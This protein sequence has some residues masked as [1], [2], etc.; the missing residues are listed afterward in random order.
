M[1]YPNTLQR[2]MVGTIVETPITG[3]A[4]LHKLDTL[5]TSIKVMSTTKGLHNHH[6]FLSVLTTQVAPKISNS[7]RPLLQIT[8]AKF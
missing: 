5:E 6:V 1:T 2:G 4:I 7:N 8:N 3:E